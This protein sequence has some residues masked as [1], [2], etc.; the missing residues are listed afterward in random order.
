MFCP[1]VGHGVVFQLVNNRGDVAPK[2]ARN[3]AIGKQLPHGVYHRFYKFR[4]KGGAQR[5]FV[6]GI[7]KM[8]GRGGEPL[9]QR[10]IV[11]AAKGNA[12]RGFVLQPKGEIPPRFACAGCAGDLPAIVRFGVVA[13]QDAR[14]AFVILLAVEPQRQGVDV[15]ALGGGNGGD[16]LAQSGCK[17]G[18]VAGLRVGHG[19][20]CGLTME[21]Q[22]EKRKWAF[23]AACLAVTRWRFQFSRQHG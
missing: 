6:V 4:A 19:F 5:C 9:R 2:R 10:G 22:P 11:F 7:A 20:L 8:I 3:R 12:G 1:A 17:I 13:E 16:G 21:R 14:V 23:Q 15:A 18:G